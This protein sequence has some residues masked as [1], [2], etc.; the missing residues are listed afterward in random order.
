MDATIRELRRDVRD[1][2]EERAASKAVAREASRRVAAVFAIAG[3]ALTV[4]NIGV[5]IYLQG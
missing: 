5:A 1:L 2:R 3:L 4:L